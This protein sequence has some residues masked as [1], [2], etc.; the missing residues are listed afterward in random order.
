MLREA[1]GE[2]GCALML[3]SLSMPQSAVERTYYLG[4]AKFHR[5][6]RTMLE[7]GYQTARLEE[8]VAGR[9]TR[10]RVLLTFDDGYDDLYSELFPSVLELKLNPVIFL[11]ADRSELS[12]FWDHTRGL[13]RRELLT[14]EQIR[15]MQRHGVEFGSHT[16]SHP[17]LPDLSDDQLR[18]EV[19]DSKHTLEDMLGAEVR[20]F[21]YPYGGV[22]ERVRAAVAEAGYKLAFTT[23]PGLNWW[24]DPLTLNR[25]DINEQDS[26]LDF[27]LKVRSG[28]SAIQWMMARARAME[29]RI[30][31]ERVRS[32]LRAVYRGVIARAPVAVPPRRK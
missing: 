3:H 26:L 2:P 25:A 22:D 15:E 14:L 1:A 23:L 6:L 19:R 8:W 13:R 10:K 28:Y 17:W 4:P 18:H 32:M 12:N 21:A 31:S 27:K 24:S 11:V 30:P 7:A 16:M 20:A 9:F 29:A 5:Y